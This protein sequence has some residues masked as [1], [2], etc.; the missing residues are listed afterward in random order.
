MPIRPSPAALRGLD[1][2]VRRLVVDQVR[3]DALREEVVDTA[4]HEAL[5]V[6]DGQKGYDAHGR[7][8]YADMRR[9]PRGGLFS[10]F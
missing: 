10:Q 8:A 9:G 2:R 6:E 4:F 5:L 7:S 3:L 1:G